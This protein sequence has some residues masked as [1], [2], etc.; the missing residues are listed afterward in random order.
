MNSLVLFSAFW[1]LVAANYTVEEVKE[2]YKKIFQIKAGEHPEFGPYMNS[3]VSK[4]PSEHFL[5]GFV[6]ENYWLIHYLQE[7]GAE[8]DHGKLHELRNE[9]AELAEYYHRSLVEDEPFNSALLA[10]V[11]RYLGSRGMELVGHVDPAR[12]VVTA[13]QLTMVAVRFFNPDRITETGGIQAHICVGIN[14]LRDFEGERDVMM[15]AFCYESIF[16]ELG[17]KQYGM[18]DEFKSILTRVK[19]LQLSKDKAVKL[20]RAQGAVWALLASNAKLRK[21]LSN[22]YKM[23]KGYLPFVVEGLEP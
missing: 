7:H 11:G 16:E 21:V 2:E 3:E 10:L 17:S 5:H 23:K 1:S 6:K 18:L 4:L 15:E 19:G 20:S 22:A 14:G 13:D 8:I 12:E 9:P